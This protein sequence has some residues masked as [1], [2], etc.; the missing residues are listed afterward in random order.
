MKLQTDRLILQ[1]LTENDIAVIHEFHC[2]PRVE[3]YNTIGI[4]ENQE[5][6]KGWLKPAMDDQENAIRSLY[7]WT[8]GL[9][10]DNTFIGEAGMSVSNNRFQF[11][12]IH[13]HVVPEL[14]GKGYATEIAKE[15]IRF[16]FEDLN[17]HRVQ[18]G[19]A[20]EN[21][22]SHKVLEKAGMIKEG[23]RRKILPIRGEW[24]DNYT[25]AILDTDP[26]P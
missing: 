25:Y 12:E 9:K 23:I 5:V 18:A 10:S 14:W 6:T 20:T 13:Y 3:R 21:I 15:L 22:G 24:Y 1:E 11:A 19:A 16:A 17:L 4:P 2:D 7:S 8:V 26:R